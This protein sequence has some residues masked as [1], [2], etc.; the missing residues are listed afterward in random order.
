MPYIND[1]GA[2]PWT[3]VIDNVGTGLQNVLQR[4]ANIDTQREN[5]Q[6]AETEKNRLLHPA[7]QKWMRKIMTGEMTPVE[8]AAAAHQEID[9]ISGPPMVSGGQA[10]QPGSTGKL[11]TPGDMGDTSQPFA[12]NPQAAP[13][14]LAAARAPQG[15]AYQDRPFNVQDA[16]DA[17]NLAP[18]ERA[19]RPDP[20]TAINARRDAKLVTDAASGGRTTSN[21]KL[22]I[23]SAE[24]IA[25]GQLRLGYEKLAQAWNLKLRELDEAMARVKEKGATDKD[26]AKAKIIAGQYNAL[27]AA[28]AKEISRLGG[29]DSEAA[30]AIREA[31]DEAE[32]KGKQV[33]DLLGQIVP[34]K[35]SDAPDALAGSIKDS[36]AAKKGGAPVTPSAAEAPVPPAAT[37]DPGT[38]PIPGSPVDVP[39]ASVAAQ[40]P[41]PA[42]VQPQKKSKTIM[43][44]FKGPKGFFNAPVPFDKIEAALKKGGTR[45]G[46]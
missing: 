18:L 16:H 8:A 5:E 22:K 9:S 15:S 29:D 1:F 39:P 31:H 46:G 25:A 27:V 2:K 28:G 17:V 44:R 6:K 43:M 7:T 35:P 36:L 20:V 40:P 32:Q 34:T 37:P 33:N 42:P 24:S 30:N 12:G 10:P 4:N 3:E 11:M 23:G 21:L 41:A 13:S 38:P 45:V 14:G 19:Q 26:I